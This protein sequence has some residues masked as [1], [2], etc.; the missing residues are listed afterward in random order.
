VGRSPPGPPS[1]PACREPAP[2]DEHYR[3][4]IHDAG[5][6]Q[7][8]RRQVS[9]AKFKAMSLIS[10]DVSAHIRKIRRCSSWAPTAIVL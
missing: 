6:I 10:S 9:N 1:L 3:E 5:E 2:V 4:P 8:N 7:P